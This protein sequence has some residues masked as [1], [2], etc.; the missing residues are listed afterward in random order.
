MAKK[1]EVVKRTKEST[2]LRGKNGKQFALLTPSGKMKRYQR[3]IKSG[4]N[5]RTG[6]P[7]SDV[8]VGYRMGYR[9]ALGEQAS[10]YKKRN[11]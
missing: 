7:L 4:R 11:R 10:I 8:A 6:E 2:V 1:F 3:E 9:S 5:S